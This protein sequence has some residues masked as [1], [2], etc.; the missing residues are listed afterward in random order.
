MS[1]VLFQQ[2]RY[3]RSSRLEAWQQEVNAA[4]SQNG[5]GRKGG[6]GRAEAWPGSRPSMQ[7]VF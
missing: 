2:V 6:G 7:V 1:T 3:T 4:R 5:R